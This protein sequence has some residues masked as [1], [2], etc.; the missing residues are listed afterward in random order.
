MRLYPIKK[1]LNAFEQTS[2][3]YESV[4]DDAKAAIES[5]P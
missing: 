5:E 1:W 2:A 3:N 4:R